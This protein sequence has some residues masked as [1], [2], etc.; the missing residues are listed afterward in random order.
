MKK[1][2]KC[3]KEEIEKLGEDWCNDCKNKTEKFVCMYCLTSFLMCGH[4]VKEKRQCTVT[5]SR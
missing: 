2:P 5:K 1:C 3:G 4:V